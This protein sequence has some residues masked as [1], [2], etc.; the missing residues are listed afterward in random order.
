MAN[1]TLYNL[2]RHKNTQLTSYDAPAFLEGE[3]AREN[4]PILVLL[5]P[6]LTLL[7]MSS[8]ICNLACN[9]NVYL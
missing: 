6:A 3:K 9:I 1:S 5:R 2:L 4:V 7:L 8:A